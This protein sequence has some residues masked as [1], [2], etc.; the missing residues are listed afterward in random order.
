M[1]TT[2]EAAKILGVSRRRVLSLIESGQLSAQKTGN[3]WLL[4]DEAVAQLNKPDARK[5][6][7]PKNGSRAME[8]RFILMNRTYPITDVVYDASSHEFTSVGS[9]QDP[10]RAPLGLANP[11]GSISPFS[12]NSWWRNRGIPEG[13]ANIQE[14]LSS[15]GISVAAELSLRSLGL[16]LSDQY[17][18]CPFESGIEWENVNFFNN[19]FPDTLHV[20]GAPEFS[21]HPDNTSDGMLAKHWVL[22]NEKRILLKGGNHNDQ[23]PFNEV[24]ATAL[25]KR[26]LKHAEYVPYHLDQLEGKPA[27]SCTCFVGDNEEFIPALY[28][29]KSMAQPAHHNDYRH[30]VECCTALGISSVQSS[31]ARTIVCDDILAN[32]DRHARNYGIIRNVET[33][34]CRMAPIFDSGT[35][36]WCTTP[37]ADLKLGDYAFKSRQFNSS[38]AKQLLLAEDLSWVDTKALKG[39]VEEA[40]AI[41]SKNESIQDRIPYIEK[42]LTA[43]VARMTAICEAL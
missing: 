36:L 40:V 11:Q 18:L 32:T 6:G 19:A 17:W 38:P 14:I 41:L 39:F 1:L 16:S 25:H 21:L 12:F 10:Y 3:M 20:E 9:L 2:N 34:E 15:A 5:V 7:R 31:L 35:S 24:I 43:R 22:R 29:A 4:E 30:Y 37:Y 13:R 23:E 8:S 28:V 26:L 42:A 27:S 33:L